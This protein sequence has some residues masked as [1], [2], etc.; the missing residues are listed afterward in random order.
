M[1]AVDD[2]CILYW[3]LQ[4]N[5]VHLQV[6]SDAEDGWSTVY[7]GN[8]HSCALPLSKLNSVRHARLVTSQLL[9]EQHSRCRTFSSSIRRSKKGED[10]VAHCSSSKLIQLCS[11][12]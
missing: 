12:P 9:V 3:R 8:S 11:T 5:D 10:S 7:N 4:L 1:S 2:G 6:C